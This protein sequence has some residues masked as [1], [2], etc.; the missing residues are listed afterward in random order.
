MFRQLAKV[1]Y[2]QVNSL[3]QG[4]VSLMPL[5]LRI[6]MPVK[7]WRTTPF[8]TL[9]TVEPNLFNLLYRLKG[10]RNTVSHGE[11]FREM[12]F[13]EIN[14]LYIRVKKVITFLYLNR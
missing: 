1:T 6:F 8:S 11:Q 13:D 5:W 7:I 4:N 12:G 2:G 9:A 10:L 14:S 3:S